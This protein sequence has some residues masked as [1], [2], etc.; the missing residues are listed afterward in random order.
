M[1]AAARTVLLGTLLAFTAGAVDTLGFVALFGLFTAHVTGNFVLI[2]AALAHDAGG[3]V[4]K[5]LALPVF[6]GV[7]ALA[8]VF[9]L[10]CQRA[11]RPAGRALVAA[12][13]LL[14]AGFLA[15]A[16]LAA[17]TAV[18][19][20]AAIA[21]GML[22]VAAMALQNAAA[23]TVFGNLAPTTVMTG[24]V[25]QIVIDLVDLARGIDVAAARGRLR[26]FLPAVGAFAIGA[27]AGALGFVQFGFWALLAP[28]AATAAV[29]LL[30]PKES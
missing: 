16:L 29:A 27:L 15:A 21:V 28:I 4:A 1:T 2:G 11:G 9:H 13:V 14:L 26:K 25:T 24:N 6:V 3:L 7:V 20:L 12:Q 17:P 8:R 23:R 30:V 18:D 22:G 5:L 10:S 19:S